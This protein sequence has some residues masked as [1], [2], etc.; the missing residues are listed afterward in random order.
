MESIEVGYGFQAWTDDGQVQINDRFPNYF[1]VDQGYENGGF[2]SPTER[3]YTKK[4][5]ANVPQGDT[6][7]FDHYMVALRP[8][9]DVGANVTLDGFGPLAGTDEYVPRFNLWTEQSNAQVYWYVFALGDVEPLP[10]L[11]DY[12]LCV[13]DDAGRVTDRSDQKVLRI[14]DVVAGGTF[15]ASRT[16]PSGKTYAFVSGGRKVAFVSNKTYYPWGKV[17]GNVVSF[18]E[19]AG[20]LEGFY[21]DRYMSQVIVDVTNY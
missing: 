18:Y 11:P 3:G 5:W 10:P 12:G 1:L 7:L 2:T 17:N 9:N 21:Y 15:T 13:F 16:L 19:T 6:S 4:I 20:P 14:V 8:V